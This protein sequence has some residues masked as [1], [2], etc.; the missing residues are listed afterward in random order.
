VLLV[1]FIGHSFMAVGRHHRM[2][3]QRYDGDAG[4]MTDVAAFLAQQTT[5]PL[6]LFSYLQAGEYLLAHLLVHLAVASVTS[7]LL[8]LVATA[9]VIA[10]GG[11]PS[12]V[13]WALVASRLWVWNFLAKSWPTLLAKVVLPL[14]ALVGVDLMAVFAPVRAALLRVAL[15]VWVSDGPLVL[16]PRLLLNADALFTATVGAVLGV[17]DGFTR[18]IVSVVWGLLRCV[19]LHEPVVPLAAAGIDRPFMAYGGML[20]SAHM[21]QLQRAGGGFGFGGKVIDP[22]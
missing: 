21:A 18:I 2:L 7:L 15:W 19:I 6:R 3:V 14:F 20:R 11:V 13:A 10:F 12:L 5:P 17:V 9:V 8:I 16:A 4:D 22:A 1:G